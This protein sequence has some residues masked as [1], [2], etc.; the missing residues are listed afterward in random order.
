MAQVY[1]SSMINA[2]ASDVW[3][4]IRNFNGLPDW[5][6]FVAESRIEQA[7]PPDQIGCVR[8]FTL[9]NGSRIRER[10]LALS[11]YDLSCTYS[12]LESEMGVENYVATL[13]LTPVTDGN[14][15]FAEWTA[16]FDCPEEREQALVREIG[17]GVF[18][19]AFNALKQR[20]R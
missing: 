4:V 14:T 8:N 7:M 5:T 15:T 13:S 16:E 11:D 18:Q 19:S 3:R 12:I 9:K 10:L 2:P 6:P 20:F 17:Q 1:V